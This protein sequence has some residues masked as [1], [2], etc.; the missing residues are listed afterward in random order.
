MAHAEVA[1]SKQEARGDETTLFG[2]WV[3]LMTDLVLFASLFAVFVT[4]RGNPIA[5]SGIFN[6]NVVLAETL[7]LLTSS[8]T[9]GLT[10]LFAQQERLQGTLLWLCATFLLGA[11]FIYLE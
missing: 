8:F 2:F 5:H 11:A 3:Y 1:L 6:M 10:L 9:Y 7:F 4:L